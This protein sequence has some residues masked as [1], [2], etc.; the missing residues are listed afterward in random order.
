MYITYRKLET[1]KHLILCGFEGLFLRKCVLEMEMSFMTI[2]LRFFKGFNP[3][4]SFPRTSN[5]HGNLESGND[6]E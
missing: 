5:F 6:F 4:L 2:K 1:G 3:A